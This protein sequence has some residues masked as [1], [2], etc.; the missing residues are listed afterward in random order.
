M[1]AQEIDVTPAMIAAGVTAFLDWVEKKD[2]SHA[3]LVVM[4]YRAMIARKTDDEFDL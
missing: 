4:I 1:T 2:N 3:S